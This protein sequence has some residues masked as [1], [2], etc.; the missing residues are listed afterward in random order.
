MKSNDFKKMAK[1]LCKKIVNME[2]TECVI[3]LEKI[4]VGTLIMP[5]CH[6]QLCL[7]C[8][9]LT[10]ECPLCRSNI[11]YILHYGKEDEYLENI[12]NLADAI[13]YSVN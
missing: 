10:S 11:D 8:S 12:H 3:C 1:I 7:T 9:A 4:K 2:N 13:N 5:C 6:Y